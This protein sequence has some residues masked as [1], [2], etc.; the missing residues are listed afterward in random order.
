VSGNKIM[1]SSAVTAMG[2][3]SVIHHIAIHS[4]DAKTALEASFRPGGL[5][6][7]RVKKNITGPK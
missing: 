1:G 4:E 5:K 7:K 3:A 6:N 2:S